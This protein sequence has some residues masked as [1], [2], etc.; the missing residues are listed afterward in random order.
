MN[1]VIM[2]FKTILT[3]M[4]L[5]ACSSAYAIDFGVGVKAGTVGVGAEI[6][7]ALTQT[8]NARV[9]MTSIDIDDLDD[10]LTVGDSGAEG[11]IDAVMSFDFGANALL[12][13]WYVFDG[14]FHVTAGMM[15]NNGKID[16]SGQLVGGSILIDGQPIDA[17]D[18]Q[19]DIGG[20]ISAGESYEPY[21]GIGWGRKADDDPGLSLS[22]E[23]GVA[24]LDP[25]AELSATLDPGSTN[26]SGQAQL[27]ATLRDMENDINSE[28]S[29]LEAWP[30]LSVGLNYAF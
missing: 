15:K 3:A 12:L 24:L 28:L 18:I 2:K 10:T 23:I 8:I 21:V 6:S 19:G 7:V 26:F 11:D 1:G 14:T 25:S 20:S 13:D 4:L 5:L 9:A 16:F 30:I 29:V 22:V 27:D 17:G